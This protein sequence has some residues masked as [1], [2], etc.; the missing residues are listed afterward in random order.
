MVRGDGGKGREGGRDGDMVEGRGNAFPVSVKLSSY[1]VF[2]GR[3][4]AL[5]STSLNRRCYV[6]GL[7][8][9]VPDM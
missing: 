1:G 4:D 3:T 9:V 5:A 8:G 2:L 7:G 6:D